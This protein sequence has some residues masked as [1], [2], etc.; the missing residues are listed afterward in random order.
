[1]QLFG[2]LMRL[3]GVGEDWQLEEFCRDEWS[4]LVGSL[5]LY[6]GDRHLGEELAQEALVRV[7]EHWRDVAQAESPSAWAHRVAF[8]LAKSH[9]RRRVAFRRARSQIQPRPA[10]EPDVASAVAVRV[11]VASLPDAQ[12]RALVLR[13]FADLSLREVAAVMHCPENTVKSHVRRAL[14]ALRHVGLASL[15]DQSCA[16]AGG[17]A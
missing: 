6:L 5:T 3:C 4:R 15:V 8:N 11:A 17:S 10:V 13:Y 12:R 2:L 14:E 7:V 1:M 9:L 16:T